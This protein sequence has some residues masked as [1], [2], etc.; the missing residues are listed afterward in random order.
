MT[1]TQSALWQYLYGQRVRWI[2]NESGKLLIHPEEIGEH[3]YGEKVIPSGFFDDP[4]AANVSAVLFSNA[5]TLSKFD[6]MGIVAG[7][8]VP[9][10]RYLRIGMKVNPDP[11]AVVGTMFRADVMA[12]GYEEFW[13]DE[14]QVFHNPSTTHPLPFEALP[15]ATHHFI[16]DDRLRS[17][18]PEGAILSSYSFIFRPQPVDKAEGS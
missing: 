1:Y 8:G 4:L 2:F 9:G 16:R 6:R 12:P 13:T 7:F 5:G 11:N 17:W 10:I 14:I 3:R 15:G 18:G